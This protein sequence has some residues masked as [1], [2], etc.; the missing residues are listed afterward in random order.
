MLLY[1]LEIIAELRDAVFGELDP[2]RRS[3]SPEGMHERF[4]WHLPFVYAFRADCANKK[5]I[6]SQVSL[7]LYPSIS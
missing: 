3:V 2:E 4:S 7:S 1:E 6:K 5:G